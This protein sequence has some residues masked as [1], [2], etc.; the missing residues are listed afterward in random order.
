MNQHTFIAVKPD[1]VERELTNDILDRF[2]AVGLRLVRSQTVRAS[3]A[4]AKEH[5]AEHEGKHFF[6]KL[7]DFI[8]SG[9]VFAM[10]WEGPDAVATGRRLIGK[11]DQPGT[12]RGDY[13]LP[14][15]TTKNIVHG[16]DSPAAASRE[17]ALWFTGSTPSVSAARSSPNRK[18][19]VEQ[20]PKLFFVRS[21]GS[22]ANAPS[23]YDRGRTTRTLTIPPRQLTI[24][25]TDITL[26]DEDR[27]KIKNTTISE[28]DAI[29]TEMQFVPYQPQPRRLVAIPG[30]PKVEY[31]EFTIGSVPQ[32][33]S[34]NELPTN[35]KNFLVYRQLQLQ[36]ER[37]LQQR[38]EQERELYQQHQVRESRFPIQPQSS[39]AAL[40]AYEAM[41]KQQSKAANGLLSPP[42]VPHSATRS[43][44]DTSDL[45]TSGFGG[46]SLDMLRRD[47]VAYNEHRAAR[48]RDLEERLHAVLH[49]SSDDGR[50]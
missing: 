41:M 44:S 18:K 47:T 11:A 35:S 49:G 34:P 3:E 27:E 10:E 17:L 48:T 15:E 23:G 25:V 45:N 40:A 39:A 26:T 24:P 19:E 28:A 5:Y 6:G 1:G 32:V 20:P 29:Q 46:F 13:T 38:L 37:E 42:P 8:T 14:G 33:I 2:Q 30:P 4:L 9:P 12:I 22:L 21:D 7:V 43:A 50:R 36:Q 16:S 31:N